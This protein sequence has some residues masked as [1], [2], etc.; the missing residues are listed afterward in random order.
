MTYLLCL[1]FKT[2]TLVS[3]NCLGQHDVR[4]HPPWFI[5]YKMEWA[6]ARCYCECVKQNCITMETAQ[7][8]CFRRVAF[9]N[10]R[11]TSAI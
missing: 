6:C 4:T 8:K 3:G 1:P 5:K 10:G 2:G 7:Q 11:Q 9:G